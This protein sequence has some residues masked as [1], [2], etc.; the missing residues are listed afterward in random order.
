MHWAA[1][2]NDLAM[3][4]M[5]IAGGANVRTPN[6]EGATPMSLAATNGSSLMIERLLSAGADADERG[7]QG[8]TSLMLAS[9]NGN[10]DAMKVLLDHKASVNA[11]EKLRGTTALM[12][13]AEQ[14]HAAAVKLLLLH[15][16]DV[17]AASNPDTRNAR[18]NLANT[19]TERL[20]S[21]LGAIGQ[22]KARGLCRVASA[23]GREHATFS[24]A[25]AENRWRRAYAAYLCR[26]RR[27]PRVRRNPAGAWSRREPALALR[28]DSA[29]G[30]N[31]KPPLQAGPISA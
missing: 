3:A 30:G 23:R 22:S 17:S 1:Y 2:K 8:E 15:G 18:N 27:L 19:V 26:A 9:R 5:L 31:A 12:W 24:K 13:A 20:N 29:V 10:V 4:E 16:A 21:S 6:R 7:P 25:R 14:G 11:K 28:L